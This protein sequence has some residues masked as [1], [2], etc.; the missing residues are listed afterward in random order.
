[1]VARRG[2]CRHLMARLADGVPTPVDGRGPTA[3]LGRFSA[4]AAVHVGRPFLA[5]FGAPLPGPHETGIEEIEPVEQ[6]T[7]LFPGTV[8]RGCGR[9]LVDLDG[10]GHGIGAWTV[11]GGVAESEIA[12]WRHG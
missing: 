3:V 4:D 12:S 6:R 8:G 11:D 9:L 1:M 5:P 10:L 7:D 2:R